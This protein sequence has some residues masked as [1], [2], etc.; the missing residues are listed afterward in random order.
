MAP[1]AQVAV[2]LNCNCNAA[3]GPHAH[4][5]MCGDPIHPAHPCTRCIN[6][7]EKLGSGG[8]RWLQD[9]IKKAIDNHR[10]L[11]HPERRRKG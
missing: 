4:C 8:V 11:Y 1:G 9:V 3:Y 7:E 2:R 10:F 5:E 6:A